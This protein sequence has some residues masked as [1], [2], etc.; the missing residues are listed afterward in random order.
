MEVGT[1]APRGH[2]MEPRNALVLCWILAVGLAQ[3]AYLVAPWL[4]AVPALLAA[5]IVPAVI[6]GSTS[7]R[8]WSGLLLLSAAVVPLAP[9]AGWLVGATGAAV[10]LQRRAPLRRGDSEADLRR[11]IERCRRA[12]TPAFA[13]VADV[14][15]AAGVD[16]HSVRDTFRLAD[17]VEVVHSGSRFHVRGVITDLAEFRPAGLGERLELEL[18]TSVATG[19]A[20]FP[21]E[22]LTL[23]LLLEHAEAD[24][25]SANVASAH[26][27]ASRAA[28]P[29]EYALATTGA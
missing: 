12:E 5:I 24:L 13:F 11:Q 22:G 25:R 14:S 2:G 28:T 26:E 7:A 3:A 23:D 16:A 8:A 21:E 4:V 19:W 18:G 27:I 29:R 9:A 17:T 1:L 10:V 6:G 20:R 15:D